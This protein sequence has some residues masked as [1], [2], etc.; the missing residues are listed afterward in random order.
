VGT[1]RGVPDLSMSAACDGSVL[2][3]QSY[4][5]T[6]AGFYLVCGTSEATPE[7]AGIVSLADQ[8]AGHPL[9]LINPTLYKLEQQNAPGIV[10]IKRGNNTVT[11]VQG[12]PPVSYTVQ[13]FKAVPGYDLASGVGTVNAWYLA[14]ELAGKPVP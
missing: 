4:P 8:I 3:Y 10:D 9:G 11:F 1:A 13:G 12:N 6:T 2:V 5:G 7:F 14:Y